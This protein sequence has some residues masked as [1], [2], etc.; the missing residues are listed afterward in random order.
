LELLKIG[1]KSQTIEHQPEI[2]FV[3][4]SDVEVR[5]VEVSKHAHRI[6]KAVGNKRP[7]L[8]LAEP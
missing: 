2:F 4:F 1:C 6:R 3:C 8:R 7:F 5:E